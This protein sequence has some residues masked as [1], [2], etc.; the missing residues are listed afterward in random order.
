LLDVDQVVVV[1]H[2]LTMQNDPLTGISRPLG[3]RIRPDETGNGTLV[4]GLVRLWSEDPRASG[5]LM[6]G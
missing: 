5:T 1:I 2:A 6:R 4:G 3:A